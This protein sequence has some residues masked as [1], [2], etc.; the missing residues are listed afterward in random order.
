MDRFEQRR[1]EDDIQMLT[2]SKA[3]P[4]GGPDH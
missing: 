3:N 2:E 4:S 1:L